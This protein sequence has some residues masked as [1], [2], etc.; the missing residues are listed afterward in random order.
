[1][2]ATQIGTWLLVVAV[3]VDIATSFVIPSFSR[4]LIPP[5]RKWSNERV[6][7]SDVSDVPSDVNDAEAD[8]TSTTSFTSSKDSQETGIGEWEELHGNYLLRPPTTQQQPRALIHFLGGALVGAAPDISYRYVLESL[9]ARGFLIVATPYT[10][11]FDYIAT[12]DD[13]IGRFEKIAPDLARQFGPVPVVG[14]GHSCGALLQLLIT[15][16][17]PD[18]PR[19]ANALMSYNN[20]SAKEAV[21][22]F[23]EVFAPLFTSLAQNGTLITEFLGEGSDYP[24]SAVELMNIGLQLS[25]NAVEGTYVSNCHEISFY[26]VIQ[27]QHVRPLQAPFHQMSS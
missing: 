14:V 22:L 12:C 13:I 18:T 27:L 24:P 6:F 8:T 1:M 3:T 4:L 5:E 26:L 10:L 2:I 7:M 9:A 11:S 17:F 19:A 23:D 21:P 20:K 25:R 16:L 15:T